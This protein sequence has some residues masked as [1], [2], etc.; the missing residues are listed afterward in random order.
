MLFIHTFRKIMSHFFDTG[1]HQQSRKELFSAISKCTFSFIRLLRPDGIQLKFLMPA[2]Y[3]SEHMRDWQVVYEA[4]AFS[5]CFFLVLTLCTAELDG[6]C[7]WLFTM[8]FINEYMHS[9]A[10]D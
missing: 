7:S 3:F 6:K 8:M 9:H 4:S 10:R 2:Q 5:T 1:I